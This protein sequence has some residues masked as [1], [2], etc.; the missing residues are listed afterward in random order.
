MIERIH[1]NI[2]R[3][4]EREGSLTAAAQ[5]LHLTQSALSHAIKKLESQAGTTIWRRE[6]RRIRLTPAGHYLL[7]EAERLLPQLDRID[8]T[9]MDYAHGRYGSLRI[10]ME[11]H[12]CYRWLLK[13]V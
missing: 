9:L 6:G 1:L 11:C 5:S 8:S 12:P 13:V 10:G 3:Q 7:A 2:L 4:I